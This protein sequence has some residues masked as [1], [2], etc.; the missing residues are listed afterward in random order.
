MV[1]LRLVTKMQYSIDTINNSPFRKT[2]GIKSI[3]IFLSPQLLFSD[4]IYLLP[5]YAVAVTVMVSLTV[6][7]SVVVA[8]TVKIWLGGMGVMM[9][10]PSDVVEDEDGEEGVGSGAGGG[11]SDDAD[12]V[13]VGVASGVDAGASGEDGDGGGDG[14]CEGSRVEVVDVD[15]CA[16]GSGV[17][18]VDGDGC[19]GGSTGGVEE[20]A[21][22]A[23][24]E[25]SGEGGEELLG[26]AGGVGAADAEVASDAEE[27]FEELGT[28][29]S[30]TADVAGTWGASLGAS[31]AMTVVND[32]TITTGGTCK[33]SDG[34]ARAAELATGGTA[35]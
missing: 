9:R 10:G 35:S 6:S 29:G 31:V 17:G 30:G 4:K 18:V 34:T 28:T 7:F 12:G 8:V 11:S 14:S 22:C 15:G 2:R 19:A 16:E 1:D 5:H 3:Y 24:V 13:V 25:L 26:A 32:V 27:A 23:D 20:E 21:G 33:D